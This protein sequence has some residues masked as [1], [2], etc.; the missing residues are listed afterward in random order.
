MAVGVDPSTTGGTATT[1]ATSTT[2]ATMKEL[3]SDLWTFADRG[4]WI[5]IT[6][7]G[8]IRHD[9]RLVM[10]RG[11]ALQAAQRWPKLPV[12]LG[13]IVGRSGNHVYTMLKYKLFTYPVKEKF[14][15]AAELRLIRWS[16]EQLVEQVD[17]MSRHYERLHEPTLTQVYMVRPGCGNGGLTWKVVKPEI[18]YILDDRFIVVEREV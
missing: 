16:A 5:V 13:A 4:E 12:D 3:P 17:V 6:T 9:G 1:T 2:C 18:K 8:T 14:Y 11:V 10:G 15:D 7:N